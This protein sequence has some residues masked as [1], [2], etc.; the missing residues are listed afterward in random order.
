MTVF[1]GDATGERS[2]GVALVALDLRTLLS[3]LLF[4]TRFV[5]IWLAMAVLLV[6][7]KI[8]APS[9][10]SSA[11]WARCCRSAASSPSSPSVRC[12]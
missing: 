7:C 8:F 5:T 12:W 9:T 3:N 6:I 2:C 11:S 4:G 10:L 1:D